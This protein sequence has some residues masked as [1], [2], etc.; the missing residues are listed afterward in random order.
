MPMVADLVSSIRF[1]HIKPYFLGSTAISR[2]CH[3]FSFTEWYS[4]RRP[5]SSFPTSVLYIKYI[6]YGT[7]V[8]NCPHRTQSAIIREFQ[9]W[10]FSGVLL[11]SF[12]CRICYGGFWNNFLQSSPRSLTY[13]TTPVVTYLAIFSSI[14]SSTGNTIFIIAV[15]IKLVVNL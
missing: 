9:L 1:R 2:V 13:P 12:P 11:S 5:R 8:G 7:V 14:W 15:F 10:L 6:E 3:F 4:P